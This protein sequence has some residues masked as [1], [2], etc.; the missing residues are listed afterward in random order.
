MELRRYFGNIIDY[1]VAFFCYLSQGISKQP[2]LQY[3]I[4]TF[5][6]S[7]KS[8]MLWTVTSS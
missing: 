7:Q 1:L 6:G 4:N 2:P 8:N 5:I 3:I